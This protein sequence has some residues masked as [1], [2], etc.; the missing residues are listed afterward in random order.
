[1]LARLLHLAAPLLAAGQV[2]SICE[3]LVRMLWLGVMAP[4]TAGANGSISGSSVSTLLSKNVD[5]A[6]DSEAAAGCR[7]LC[8]HAPTALAL[9]DAVEA[10]HQ[11]PRAGVVPL[12]QNLVDAFAT[13]LEALAAEFQSRAP[14]GRHILGCGIRATMPRNEDSAAS[15][16][17]R[18]RALQVRSNLV[19]YARKGSPSAGHEESTQPGIS[20]SWPTPLV[21]SQLPEA[22]ADE[23]VREP[24]AEEPTAAITATSEVPPPEP[25]AEIPAQPSAEPP[26]VPPAEPAPEVITEKP[27]ESAAGSEPPSVVPP[28]EVSSG[29]EPVRE[30]TE[31]V[32][33]PQGNTPPDL[34]G[35]AAN[36]V[37]EVSKTPV[38]ASPAQ[39]APMDVSSGSDGAGVKSPE[40]PVDSTG[41]SGA[42]AAGPATSVASS[43]KSPEDQSAGL[44]YNNTPMDLFPGDD[45]ELS[46]IPELC[47]DSPD[48]DD[49]ALL[50]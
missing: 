44:A 10:L 7:R 31:Q 17:V 24:P 41:T 6:F 2:A 11:K 30:S 26:V 32:S 5:N 35:G 3:Q 20:I 27:S 23:E 45:G 48:S 16:P 39:A 33:E 50:P 37:L 47:M 13:L 43:T 49:A 38:L 40:L 9:I 14:L 22:D 34:Q 28:S 12:A 21:L 18:L 36:E 15:M 4:P 29:I 19:T 25:E 42:E 46:P 1:M 8:R